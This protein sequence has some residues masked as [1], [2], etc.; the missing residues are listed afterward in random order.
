M[1]AVADAVLAIALISTGAFLV[2][3]L[4]L[5]WFAVKTKRRDK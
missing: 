4:A 2:L 3:G 5:A 1:D